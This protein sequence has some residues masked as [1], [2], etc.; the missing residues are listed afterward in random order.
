MSCGCI[1]RLWK[2]THETTVKEMH[3]SMFDRWNLD[4]SKTQLYGGQHEKT[5]D[6]LRYSDTFAKQVAQFESLSNNV[7]FLGSRPNAWILNSAQ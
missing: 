2:L 1:A 7:D 4:V 5:A 3:N 6:K